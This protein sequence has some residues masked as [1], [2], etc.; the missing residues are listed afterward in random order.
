M[1]G[2]VSEGESMA[3]VTLEFAFSPLTNCLAYAMEFEQQGADQ[4]RGC[5]EDDN[6]YY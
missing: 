1:T 6:C 2:L 3:V 4:C 5:A